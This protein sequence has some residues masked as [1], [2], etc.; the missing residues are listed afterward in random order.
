MTEN[1]DSPIVDAVRRARRE[2]VEQ[3]G[4]D[5]DKLLERLKDEENASDR[6]VG[7]PKHSQTG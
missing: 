3:C 7:S 1:A 4:G 2:L 6:P 5:L